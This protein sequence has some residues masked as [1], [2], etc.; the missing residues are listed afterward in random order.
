MDENFLFAIGE[1]L[2]TEVKENVAT[3][4]VTQSLSAIESGD[5]VS[6][7]RETDKK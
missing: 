3:V 4:M 2:A 7:R 1:G 6:L 5:Y